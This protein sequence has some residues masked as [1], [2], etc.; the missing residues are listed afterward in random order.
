MG[1]GS[2]TLR[3]NLGKS[4]VIIHEV[5]RKVATLSTASEDAASAFY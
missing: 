5:K 4:H 3:A 2:R 1:F